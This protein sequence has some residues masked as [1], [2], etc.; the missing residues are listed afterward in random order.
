[1]AYDFFTSYARLDNNEFSNLGTV[2]TELKERVRAKLGKPSADQVGF[3]DAREIKTGADWQLFLGEALRESR[4]IV[5][6]CSPT[7]FN[8]EYCAKEFEIF[9]LRLESAGP[10][11]KHR[12][13]IPVVWEVGPT[14]R[15]PQVLAKYQ[16][17]DDRYPKVYSSSGLCALRRVKVLRDDYTQAIEAL[18][19]D[20]SSQTQ[21]SLPVWPS[22]VEFEQL[23]GAFHNP[24]PYSI[25]VAVLHQKRIRWSPS[26]GETTIATIAESIASS[27][28]APWREIVLDLS[29]NLAAELK[30][31]A[32]QREAVI[33]IT[34]A[35]SVTR[36]PHN[37][38][39]RVIDMMTLT[40]CVVLMGF[41]IAPVNGKPSVINAG[42]LNTD[43]PIPTNQFEIKLRE[44]IPNLSASSKFHSVFSLKSEQDLSVK[45]MQA[46][47]NIR[48]KLISDDPASK[49]A[50]KDIERQAREEGIPL[51]TKPIVTG[52]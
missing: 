30:K 48:M 13:V 40:N 49:V 38:L 20:I 42:A 35:T 32:A 37:E 29:P 22:S 11:F 52:P 41:P 21:Y 14:N 1:M 50:D 27:L 12:V 19:D 16:Y 9:R 31:A 4:V 46:A 3:F 8:S 24:G 15:V 7:Y 26:D 51:E 18:A 10:T 2:V 25:G 34:D 6:F 5:C 28:K 45:L 33:I 39:L 43:V 47:I 17:T 23:P 36:P 44:L